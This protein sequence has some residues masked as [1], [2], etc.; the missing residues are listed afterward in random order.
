MML[1]L[2][3]LYIIKINKLLLTLVQENISDIT[4]NTPKDHV[5][6][7]H[8]VNHLVLHNKSVSIKNMVY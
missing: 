4:G 7:S 1:I 2:I 5:C 6:D 8:F 3:Y